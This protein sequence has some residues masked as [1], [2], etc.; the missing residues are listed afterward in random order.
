MKRVLL[1]S[2][3]PCAISALN[4]MRQALRDKRSDVIDNVFSK[5]AVAMSDNEVKKRKE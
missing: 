5:K 2:V 1:K 3:K 4:A